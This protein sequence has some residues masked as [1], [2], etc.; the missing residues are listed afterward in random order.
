MYDPDFA[1]AKKRRNLDTLED[2]NDFMHLV[3]PLDDTFGE[4]DAPT[5]YRNEEIIHEVNHT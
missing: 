1:A 3:S 4:T 5:T 2:P